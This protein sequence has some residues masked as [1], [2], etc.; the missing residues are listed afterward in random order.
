MM[1]LG[2]DSSKTNYKR[3]VVY[4]YSLTENATRTGAACINYTW[5]D[6]VWIPPR[7]VSYLELRDILSI[8]RS[9]NTL[10]WGD[11]TA[12]QEHQVL[13]QMIDEQQGD[14]NQT[15]LQLIG[16]NITNENE[17]M[18]GNTGGGH[19]RE[20]I[21]QDI[22][23]AKGRPGYKN[24]TYHCPARAPRKGYK[25]LFREL[26]QLPGTRGP[27]TARN[28]SDHFPDSWSAFALKEE[29]TGKLDFAN[30]YCYR[31]T[32]KH[33]QTHRDLILREYTVLILSVG[34]WEVGLPETCG[35][36][37]ILELV[38][39]LDYV[40]D[41]LAGPSLLVVWKI[42]GPRA[43]PPPSPH[44]LPMH[45]DAAKDQTLA[46]VARNWFHAQEEEEEQQSIHLQME[47]F[48]WVVRDRSYGDQRIKGDHKAHWGLEVRLLSL[49]IVSRMI[50]E[51]RKHQKQTRIL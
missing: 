26:G 16:Y 31:D 24:I 27:C 18:G 5:V 23:K 25:S 3:P 48:R 45:T 38:E 11:S 29:P 35:K 34:M 37:P 7:G 41:H 42:H 9:E 50:E 32:L 47:D 2:V 19:Q 39:L 43:E 21:Q 10:F 8:F 22:N 14:L 6:R 36:D 49:E 51:W 46:N 44:D 17:V 1:D 15:S 13:Y 30:S 20:R 12:R 33:L 28:Y 4:K 40:K